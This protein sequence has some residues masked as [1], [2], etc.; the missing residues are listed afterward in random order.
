M[1]IPTM[2]PEQTF[3]LERLALEMAKENYALEKFMNVDKRNIPQKNG[4]QYKVSLYDHLP[5][6]AVQDLAEAT[7]VD[8]SDMVRIT[9]TGQLKRQAARV[10]YSDEMAE[11]YDLSFIKET[12]AELSYAMGT[13]HDKDGFASLLN[14]A[15]FVVD[16]GTV[17]VEEALK[18][19]RNHFRKNNVPTVNKIFDGSLKFNTTPVN[20]SWVLFCDVDDAELWRSHSEFV[21]IEDYSDGTKLMPYEI[22][23]IKSLGFTIVETLN[24]GRGNS[25][26]FGRGAFTGLGLSGKNKIEI[27]EKPLG[28]GVVADAAGNIQTDVLN[29]VGH[30]GVKS[31]DSLMV[32]YPERIIRFE[33]IPA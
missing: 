22:G 2:N 12:V 27:I 13:K 29:Q 26:A 6:D 15:G 20:E 19:A 17:S 9:R 16:M 31:R 1:R 33:N 3:F 18:L 28:S 24:I 30:I 14:E 11:T 25:V 10:S 32:I 5:D 21:P 8:E 7:T 23:R 4:S